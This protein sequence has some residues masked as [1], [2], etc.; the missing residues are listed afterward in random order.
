MSTITMSLP[1]THFRLWFGS[2][3]DPGR[4]L[5]FPCDGRGTVDLDGMT[6]RLRGSYLYARA[7]VGREFERPEVQP[8]LEA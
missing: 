4:G 3:F 2:L 1:M 7:M 6:P 5:A 8:E